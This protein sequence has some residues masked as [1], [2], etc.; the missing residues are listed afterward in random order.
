MQLPIMLS[1]KLKERGAWT[2]RENGVI[3]RQIVD[4]SEE[5]VLSEDRDGDQTDDTGSQG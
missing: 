3:T 1:G 2:R 4:I 5:I